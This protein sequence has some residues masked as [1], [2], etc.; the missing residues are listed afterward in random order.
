M[1]RSRVRLNEEDL[2]LLTALGQLNYVDAHKDAVVDLIAKFNLP[3][4][5]DALRS[6]EFNFKADMAVL[7]Q[8]YPKLVE[9]LTSAENNIVR[10]SDIKKFVKG[11]IKV[12]RKL[13][14]GMKEHAR[15]LVEAYKDLINLTSLTLLVP[16]LVDYATPKVPEK[17]R[18]IIEAM[19]FDTLTFEQIHS[20]L[21]MSVMLIENGLDLRLYNAYK[22]KNLTLTGYVNSAYFGTVVT[23]AELIG[24]TVTAIEDM[25]CFNDYASLL[26]EVIDIMGVDTTNVDLSSVNCIM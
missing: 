13:L 25:Y 6:D 24:A 15:S 10:Y 19:S 3:I 9:Y 8:A 20:D 23:R 16:E 1:A 2:R 22:N 7:A 4:S 5:L 17:Y 21:A 14:G 18:G 26:M 11:E 12:D